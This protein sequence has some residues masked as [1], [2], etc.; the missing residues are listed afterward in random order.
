MTRNTLD[1]L[2]KVVDE[3]EGM[4][5]WSFDIA[6]D[7]ETGTP[8][9]RIHHLDCM[10]AYQPDRKMPLTHSFPIPTTTYN[11]KSWRYFVFNCYR[12]VMNHELGE[13]VRWGDER[14]FAPLHGPGENPYVV[15]Q[16]RTDEERRTR[17][18]GSMR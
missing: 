1:V 15:T 3:V 12:A 8:V 7:R 6:T 13:W 16:Y 14:P 9:L 11:E 5:G 17:Q 2:R 18:D 4:P 10:D